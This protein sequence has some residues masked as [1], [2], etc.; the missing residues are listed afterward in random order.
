MREA[1]E[2]RYLHA[3][4]AHT[5][6]CVD[7]GEKLLPS[8]LTE[9]ARQVIAQLY[10]DYSQ[11]EAATH[12]GVRRNEMERTVRT[13]RQKMADWRAM[14][15]RTSQRPSPHALNGHALAPKANENGVAPCQASPRLLEDALTPARVI[16]GHV[17]EAR[18]RRCGC[19][20]DLPQ[21]V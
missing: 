6:G 9:L 2:A 15:A 7:D 11:R 19:E 5:F 10:L 21:A 18:H 1:V 13:I 16:A 20:C 3:E 17:M 8:T 4:E 14:S 12:L